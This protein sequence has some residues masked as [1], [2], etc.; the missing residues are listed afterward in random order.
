LN[1]ARLFLR[2]RVS[3]PIEILR[4]LS[5][6]SSDREIFIPL[7]FRPGAGA[8]T[9][10]PRYP[11]G[12]PLHMAAAAAV[13]GWSKAPFLVVPFSGAAA[14]LLLFLL[15]RELGLSRELSAAGGALLAA[16]PIFF[17]MAVQPMSDVVATAWVLAALLLGLKARRSAGAAIAAGAALGVAVLVRPTN[18][19]DVAGRDRLSRREP[20]GRSDG[21]P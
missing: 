2:G 11:P 7:G 1:A 9:M 21:A 17:G 18:F 3:E 6:P 19:L 16:C 8:G 10:A 12:L 14:L 20:P 4:R 15:A 13:G 5:L